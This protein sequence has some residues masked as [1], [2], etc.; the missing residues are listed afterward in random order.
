ME[1]MK[2]IEITNQ[3]HLDDKQLNLWL[4]NIYERTK[5]GMKIFIN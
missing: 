4:S 1:F 5:V 3:N 2:T